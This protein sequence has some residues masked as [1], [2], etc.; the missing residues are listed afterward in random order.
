M[1]LWIL[2]CECPRS[3]QEASG[4][5]CWSSQQ[6]R[7]RFQKIHHSISHGQ[8]H[9]CRQVDKQTLSTLK[10]VH[11]Y[12]SSFKVPTNFKQT[13]VIMTL[14][15]E[16]SLPLPVQSARC[17]W[18]LSSRAHQCSQG[19]WLTSYLLWSGMSLGTLTQNHLHHEKLMFCHHP[20]PGH[21]TTGQVLQRRLLK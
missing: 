11:F 8:S 3:S 6:P 20:Y 14:Q 1:D 15:G 19:A 10:K 17:R 2:I 21:W 18:S 7:P 5:S 9:L 12:R 13:K 4:R 16:Q